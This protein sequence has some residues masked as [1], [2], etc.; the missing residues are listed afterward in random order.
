MT[1]QLETLRNVKHISIKIEFVAARLKCWIEKATV[2]NQVK[3]QCPFLKIHSSN[4]EHYAFG[5]LDR[6]R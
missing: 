5:T 6:S 2:Y 1:Q 3:T 4:Y